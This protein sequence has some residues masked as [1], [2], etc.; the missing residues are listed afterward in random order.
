MNRLILIIFI[1]LIISP[2]FGQERNPGY[3]GKTHMIG[4]KTA[5]SPAAHRIWNEYDNLPLY[6]IYSGLQYTEAKAHNRGIKYELSYAQSVFDRY[7]FYYFPRLEQLSY[8]RLSRDDYWILSNLK[9]RYLITQLF[10]ISAY[11][12]IY[13]KKYVAPFG[14]HLDFGLGITRT[15]TNFYDLENDS[16]IQFETPKKNVGFSPKLLVAFE[17]NHIFKDHFVFQYGYQSA[18]DI[19]GFFNMLG[20]NNANVKVHDDQH[21]MHAEGSTRSFY[22]SVFNLNLG[23]AYLF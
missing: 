2:C 3:L 16:I 6:T 11:K 20:L 15:E 14:T 10:E 21:Y 8:T 17:H 13:I 5:F 23:F 22:M 19:G 1:L 18:F 4:I 9:S 7:Q 12:Q